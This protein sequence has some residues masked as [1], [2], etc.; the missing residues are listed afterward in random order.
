MNSLD[1]LDEIFK[2]V[3]TCKKC[4][5]HQYR[6]K[7]VFAEGKDDADIMLI[8][9]S[10]GKEENSSGKLFI[11]PSGNFLDELLKIANLNRKDLY[12]VRDG[13]SRRDISN[14]VYITNIVKC[15]APTYE[16][17]K[18]EITACTPYLD[19]QIEIIKPQ[20]II[21]LGSVSTKYILQKYNLTD[22][23][24][25]EIHGQIFDLAVGDLFTSNREIKIVPMYHPAVALRN[26]TMIES[27]K[28]DWQGLNK[29]I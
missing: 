11:G 17:G 26:P 19:R 22:K 6:N 9:L 25:S 3:K 2:V 23:G 8:G 13:V 18:E 20:T 16:I 29:N 28:K 27:I 24:I 10:P 21:P 4:K 14:G 5:L 15:S 12:P 1:S 7:C